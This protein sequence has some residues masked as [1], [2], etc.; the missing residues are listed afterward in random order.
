MS[1]IYKTGRNLRLFC[2]AS[3]LVNEEPEVIELLVNDLLRLVRNKINWLG[4][5]NLRNVKVFVV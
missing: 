5:N 4:S 2:P 3:Y 1:C